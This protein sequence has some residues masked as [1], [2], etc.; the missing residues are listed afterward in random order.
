M[1]TTFLDAVN[2]VLRL[3]GILR[4]DDDTI[5][6]FT[7]TQHAASI[8]FA[9]IAIQNQIA[10]MVEAITIPYEETTGTVT[11][12]GA[13]R[14]YTLPSDFERF[15]AEPRLYELDSSSNVEGIYVEQDEERNVRRIDPRYETTAGKPVRF[16]PSSG[17]TAHKIGMWPVPDAVEV[18]KFWYDK[19]VDVTTSTDAIPIT[20][21]SQFNAFCN[22]AARNFKFLRL[23]T[24]ERDMLMPKGLDQDAVIESARAT[25]LRMMKTSKAPN[26]YGRRYG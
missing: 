25:L 13:T 11:T 9:K 26:R 3:E 2:R 6:A 18:Y 19:S 17:T 12:A 24:K 1:S 8:E 21:T 20:T 14:T 5:S 4:G 7:S 15:T 16:Y 10:W 22:V 23:S